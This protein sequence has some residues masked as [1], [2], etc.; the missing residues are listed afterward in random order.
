MITLL[1]ENLYNKYNIS[2]PMKNGQPYAKCK[3]IMSNLKTRESDSTDDSEDDDKNLTNNNVID[4]N[5]T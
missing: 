2:T 3:Y 5:L 4:Q 1:E